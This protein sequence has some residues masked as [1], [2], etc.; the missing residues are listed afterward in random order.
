MGEWGGWESPPVKHLLRKWK[1]FESSKSLLLRFPSP[2]KKISPSI[3]VLYN[4]IVLCNCI[5][6]KKNYAPFS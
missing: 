6:F 3:I 2:S 1:T 5:M 4:C